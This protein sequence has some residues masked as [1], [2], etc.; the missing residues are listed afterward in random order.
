MSSAIIDASPSG[1]SSTPFYFLTGLSALSF[2]LLFTCVDLEKSRQEQQAFL[3]EEER[4]KK[5]LGGIS[6]VEEEAIATGRE[7]IQ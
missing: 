3:E 1:N 7:E 5:E 2:L 6:S 4:L